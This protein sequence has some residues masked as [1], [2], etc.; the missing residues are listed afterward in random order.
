VPVGS[1][2]TA[3]SWIGNHIEWY[4]LDTEPRFKCII[5]PGSGHAFDFI[6]PAAVYPSDG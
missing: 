1:T 3:I 2:R 4:Y 5:E 6:K